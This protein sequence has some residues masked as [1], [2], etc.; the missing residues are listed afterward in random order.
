ML[1]LWM[2]SAG[3]RPLDERGAGLDRRGR[4][5]TS[6]VRHG[7]GAPP[8]RATDLCGSGEDGV[9]RRLV[10]KVHPVAE[11]GKGA[12]HALECVVAAG[13][14]RPAAARREGRRVEQPPR[15]G[16]WRAGRAGVCVAA[17]GWRRRAA[18]GADVKAAQPWDEEAA[19]RGA[20]AAPRRR[21]GGRAA[22][23]L[24]RRGG[25]RGCNHAPSRAGAAIRRCSPRSGVRVSACGV[26]APAGSD[27]RLSCGARSCSTALYRCSRAKRG[28]IFPHRERVRGLTPTT[29]QL[30]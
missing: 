10:Q 29:L 22:A 28:P 2:S 26:G 3:A 27:E 15:H 9:P 24:V 16:A 11:R 12:R 4:P 7:K 25:G 5:Q 23:H 30:C 19:G 8:G 18:R 17:G 21:G 1:P 14:V 6:Q 13:K 20:I